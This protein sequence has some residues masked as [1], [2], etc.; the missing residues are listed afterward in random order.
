MP[1]LSA[2]FALFLKFF[3]VGCV[4]SLP[5]HDSFLLYLIQTFSVLLVPCCNNTML[6]ADMAA[7]AVESEGILQSNASQVSLFLFHY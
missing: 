3:E 4:H 7:A 1:L 6:T 2:A 5:G